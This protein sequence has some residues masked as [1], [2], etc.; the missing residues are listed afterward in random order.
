M[1]KIYLSIFI[2]TLTLFPRTYAC[3]E[4]RVADVPSNEKDCTK[5]GMEWYIN[6]NTAICVSAEEAKRLR[7]RSE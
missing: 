6:G 2:I 5:A 3:P 7:A 1:K 4:K